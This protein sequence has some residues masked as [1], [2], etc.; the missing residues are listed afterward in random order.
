M[1]IGELLYDISRYDPSGDTEV[2]VERT[3]LID[4]DGSLWRRSMDGSETRCSSD[5]VATEINADPA[6]SEVRADQVTRIAAGAVALRLLP[7]LLRLPDDGADWYEEC[8]SKAM[9]KEHLDGFSFGERNVSRVLYVN[10]ERWGWFAT[11]DGVYMLP[12]RSEDFEETNGQVPSLKAW[13]EMTF[14]ESASRTYGL[15]STTIGFVT[16]GVVVCTRVPDEGDI[17]IRVE[18][19]GDDDVETFLNWLFHGAFAEDFFQSSERGEALLA[20][21]FVE[22]TDGGTYDYIAG[23]FLVAGLKGSEDMMGSYA[24]SEWTLYVG[25]D[26]SKVDD[27]LDR[28]TARGGK[29]CD[30]VTAAR[31][32]KSPAG[33]ARRTAIEHLTRPIDN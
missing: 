4:I 14:G 33:Q 16:P 17:D 13:G 22:A 10:G 27:V 32:P 19:R 29:L 23:D 20:Q 8:W 24:S 31:D 5:D 1:S 18:Q 15:D 6:L 11:H 9:Q 2:L 21:L 3:Q 7:L 30:I 12:D 26:K 28:L 25:L